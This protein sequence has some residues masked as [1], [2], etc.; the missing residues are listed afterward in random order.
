MTRLLRFYR[1]IASSCLA[2]LAP[3]AFAEEGPEVET[4]RYEPN[5]IYRTVSILAQN[6]NSVF[7][8]GSTAHDYLDQLY[9]RVKME[10]SF[11]FNH[12]VIIEPTIRTS[13]DEPN[14][15]EFLFEQAYVYTELVPNLFLT[16]GKN[17]EYDGSGFFVNPSDLLNEDKDLFDVQYQYEG[18]VFSRFTYQKNGR[19]LAVGYIPQRGREASRGQIWTKATAEVGEVDLRFQHTYNKVALNTFGLSLS[20]FFGE[21]MELHWDGRYQQRQHEDIVVGCGTRACSTSYGAKDASGYYLAGTRYVVASRRTLILEGIQNQS[22]LDNQ[23]MGGEPIDA[24]TP[25]YYSY[26]K[27]RQASRSTQSPRATVIGRR[28]V[29][30]GIKDEG[31][32]ETVRLGLYALVNVNDASTYGQASVLYNISPLTS[33]ELQ[34]IWFAGRPRTEFG[35]RATTRIVAINLRGKF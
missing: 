34:P 8:T 30:A 10:K 25:T 28:Y 24:E 13:R 16:G 26:N 23:E 5:L 14:K 20:R 32:F 4:T 1:M 35:E 18:K 29:F 21:R 12:E 3:S 31:T 11:N 6:K 19:S 15:M 9:A 17:T 27:Q 22:G 33:I 2:V 7:H